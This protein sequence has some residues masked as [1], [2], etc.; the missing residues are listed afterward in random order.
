MLWIVLAF[1]AGMV[2]GPVL[3][4]LVTAARTR[5]TAEVDKINK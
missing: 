2:V 1:I 4:K 5:G 3:V